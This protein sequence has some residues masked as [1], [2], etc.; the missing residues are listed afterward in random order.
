MW[1]EKIFYVN[2]ILFFS[3]NQVRVR[4]IIADDV[5]TFELQKVT[6][7]DSRNLRHKIKKIFKYFLFSI[8][9]GGGR[10]VRAGGGAGV[11]GGRSSCQDHLHHGAG[12]ELLGG[13]HQRG[14]QAAEDHG[15]DAGEQLPLQLLL[16]MTAS[17]TVNSS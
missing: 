11:G 10:A 1:K 12:E 14:G 16:E 3:V 13:R 15:Q 8:F 6:L 4:D 17:E 5:N 9:E 2:N 7:S